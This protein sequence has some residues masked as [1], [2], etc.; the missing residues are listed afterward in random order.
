LQSCAQGVATNPQGDAEHGQGEDEA[1]H[2]SS[3]LVDAVSLQ[4]HGLVA[5]QAVTVYPLAQG[6]VLPQHQRQDG[7]AG[8]AIEA[9][10]LGATL[11]ADANGTRQGID[12]H[13]VDGVAADG[14][15]ANHGSFAV[16]SILQ[17]QVAG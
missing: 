8:D 13:A 16:E 5:L 12:G 15:D 11:E 6:A 2:G 4:G 14:V 17:G 1:G 3:R 10:E 9:V 7:T